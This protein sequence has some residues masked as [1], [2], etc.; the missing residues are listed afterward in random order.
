MI[1]KIFEPITG[2][3]T[4]AVTWEVVDSFFAA[5]MVAFFTGIA[6][7]LGKE[8]CANVKQGCIKRKRKRNEN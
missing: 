2:I 5:V 6:A 3:I 8:L 1:K 7:W 4:G